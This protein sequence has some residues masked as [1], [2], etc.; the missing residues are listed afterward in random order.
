[1]SSVIS[2]GLTTS[3]EIDHESSGIIM[4]NN[5]SMVWLIHSSSLN[6]AACLHLPNKSKFE[7][8]HSTCKLLHQTDYLN[9]SKIHNTHILTICEYYMKLLLSSASRS[10]HNLSTGRCNTLVLVLTCT[11]RTSPLRSLNIFIT[12]PRLQVFLGVCST[13]KTT[14][15]TFMFLCARVHFCLS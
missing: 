15:F 12:L 7:A 11:T 6:V 1:M 14:S 3:S 10:T 2:T 4:K 13:S 8:K 5:K 9:I